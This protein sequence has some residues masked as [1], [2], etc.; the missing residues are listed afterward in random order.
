M[1]K[2]SADI[3]TIDRAI[4]KGILDG[5][6]EI[7][8]I[9]KIDKLNSEIKKIFATIKEDSAGMSEDSIYQIAYHLARNKA[10]NI[11]SK[12][13]PI[14]ET[15]VELSVQESVT[16]P[17][18]KPRE[19][20][21]ENLPEEDKEITIRRAIF[22]AFDYVGGLSQATTIEHINDEGQK[23]YNWYRDKINKYTSH[24]LYQAVFQAAKKRAEEIV[25]AHKELQDRQLRRE[26]KIRKKEEAEKAEIEKQRISEVAKIELKEL[27]AKILNEQELSPAA[28]EALKY[29]K[30]I[31]LDNKKDSET[32][33]L[34]PG[35]SRDQRYK[36]KE[37]AVSM[38][39]PLA[40]EDARKYISEKTKR[41]YASA[42]TLFKAA[43]IF[44]IKC[45]EG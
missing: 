18:P 26:Q 13:E 30:L 25:L 11:V 39:A 44:L 12:K 35:T 10:K 24:D 45:Q 37:R 32:V 23:L 27:V 7:L 4:L 8:D 6:G 41:K 28:K 22:D 16:E 3:S 1:I 38:I 31:Y 29:F 2:S 33:H 20:V 14:K 43:Q 42:E 21:L 17:L 40:S 5:F 9:S 34:F 15:P 36:W 19:I